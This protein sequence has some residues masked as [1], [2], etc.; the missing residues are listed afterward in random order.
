MTNDIYNNLHYVY[1]MNPSLKRAWKDDSC[2]S[3]WSSA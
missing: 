2:K 1:S 3:L